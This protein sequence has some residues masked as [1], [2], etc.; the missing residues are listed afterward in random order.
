M[1]MT[2]SKNTRAWRSPAAAVA[3]AAALIAGAPAQV[4]AQASGGRYEIVVPAGKSEVVEVPEAYSDLMLANPAVADVLPLTSRSVYVVGKKMGSTVLSVYGPGKRLIAAANIVVS[5]DVSGLKSRINELMPTETGV[6]VSA[7]NES[8]VLSGRVSSAP[9]AQQ[10]V[11]LAETYA[12]KEKVVNMLSVQGTQQVMLSVRFVEMQRTLARQIRA[13]A[14]TGGIGATNGLPFE[15][16]PG[17]AYATIG[18]SDDGQDRYGLIQSVIR[19]GDFNL[20]VLIDALESKGVAKTLAEPT[21]VAMSGDTANFLAGGEFPVPVAIEDGD[22]TTGG[23]LSVEFKQFGVSLAFTPTVLDDGVINLVISPEVSDLDPTASVSS[24]GL[25]IP[26][27]RVRR[28]NTTIELRDGESFTIAGLLKNEYRNDIRQFPLLGDLPIVGA[29]F[30]S[31]GFQNDETELVIVVTPQ[32]AKP[33]S[34]RMATPADGFVP[35][36]DLE[37]FVFGAQSGTGLFASP[38]D[39]ALMGH[40][41]AKGGLEGSYGHVLH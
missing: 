20:D 31:T 36:S 19:R 29:L 24:G 32:L 18:D 28:A 25:S 40:D 16:I 38:E 26:G 12:G 30:R 11:K 23:R 41:P 27:L 9:K 6:T 15:V 7:A 34:G 39:R 3:I 14:T 13:N 33:V 21:L 2:K 17:R 8:I 1:R 10:L 35:P 22:G 5:A 4:H 37:L